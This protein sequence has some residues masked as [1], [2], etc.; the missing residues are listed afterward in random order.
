MMRTKASAFFII[1]VML[2]SSSCI[3][4]SNKHCWQLLDA[5]GND[6]GTV[7]DKS[8]AQMKASYPSSCN[9]Y[10]L[11]GTNYC[12]LIDN[13]IFVKDKPQEY[14][15]LFLHCYNYANA[16][17]VACDYCQIW[18]TRQ[19]NIYKPANTFRYSTVTIQRLCG[20]TVHTLFPGREIILRESADSLIVLQFSND[21]K[22]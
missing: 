2:T 3:K 13:N 22:F 16:K 12:W 21:G 8:E 15:D 20:D 10:K 1:L 7:C 18:Y 19:K 9:Y 14:I 11:G 4:V 5:F 17:K 6:V